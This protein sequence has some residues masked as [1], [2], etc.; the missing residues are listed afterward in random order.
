MVKRKY[1]FVALA[2]F[3]MATILPASAYDML[4][5]ANRASDMNAA[6]SWNDKDGNESNIAPSANTV[7]FFTTKAVVQ[8]VLSSSLT[9]IGLHFHACTNSTSAAVPRVHPADGEGGYNYSGY[10]ITGLDGAVLTLD[11][12]NNNFGWTRDLDMASMGTNSV[13]VPVVF[14]NNREHRVNVTGGRFIFEK[15]VSTHATSQFCVGAGPTAGGRVVFAASSPDFVPK[16]VAISG[17]LAIADPAALSGVTNFSA[18][19]WGWSDFNGYKIEKCCR[20]INETDKPAVINSEIFSLGD[21][22]AFYFDGG[23]FPMSNMV[24]RTNLRGSAIGGNANVTVKEIVC[25]ASEAKTFDKRGKGAFVNLGGFCVDSVYT[26]ELRVSEGTYVAMTPDGLSRRRNVLW[27][28]VYPSSPIGA[29]IG[30]DFDYSPI[31]SSDD[32]AD[33]RFNHNARPAGFAAASGVR[34]VNLYNGALLRRNM[35]HPV[36]GGNWKQFAGTMCFGAEGTAGTVVLDNDIDLNSTE[37]NAGYNEYSVSV[38]DGDAFVDA[39]LAGSVTNAPDSKPTHRYVR[40]SKKEAGVLALD[41]PCY[42]TCDGRVYAGGL[43]VNNTIDCKY[44]VYDG[45]WIGGTGKTLA[46]EIQAGGAIRGGEQGGELEVSG[47]V[48]MADGGKFIVD[49][50]EKSGENVHGCVKFKGD[51]LKLIA[52]DKVIVAPSLFSELKERR[53]VK[54]VDWSEA[55]NLQDTSLLNLSNYEV[56][57][58]TT[59]ELYASAT[60]ST[61]GSAIYLTIRPPSKPG[62]LIT[63]R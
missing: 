32:D 34:H 56:E 21:T 61:E 39:R 20:F 43:L 31:H 17:T 38:W 44:I 27:C 4:V 11:G 37:G 29:R 1:T 13:A 49:I 22:D 54:I 25:T 40:L 57:E 16:M 55:T 3:T 50:G 2:A 14:T 62:L 52:S 48:T 42:V 58:N 7:L 15:P 8:P 19:C 6:S 63:V 59:P 36:L 18:S 30:V 35:T 41:G 45:A 47:D 46:L 9:V 23:P 12:N 51:N 24:F 5:W 28:D 10:R 26:N 33:L 53:K 60:L